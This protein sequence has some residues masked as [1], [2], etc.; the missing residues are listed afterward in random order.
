MLCEEK[1][2]LLDAYVTATDRH[3]EAV[4]SLSAVAAKDNR[5][6]FTEA[7]THAEQTR[8]DA[9]EARLGLRL[10]SKTHGC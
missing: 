2:R 6:A 10:H 5:T 8:Q 1:G 4:K 7:L 9:E 3:F